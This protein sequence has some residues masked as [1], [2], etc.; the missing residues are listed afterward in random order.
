VNPGLAH[1]V[2][3]AAACI[4]GYAASRLETLAPPVE[5]PA[6]PLREAA[7]SAEAP[8]AAAA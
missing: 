7:N 5:E 2:L 4:I 6:Q 1:A 3:V 8:L